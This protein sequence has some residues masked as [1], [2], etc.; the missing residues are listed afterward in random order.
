MD[1]EA[2]M[3][4][5]INLETVTAKIAEVAATL[6]ATGKA[7]KMNVG[8]EAPIVYDGTVNPPTV[9]NIDR[10][11][12]ATISMDNATFLELSEGKTTGPSAMMRGKLKIKGDMGAALGFQGIMD[13]VRKA[14]FD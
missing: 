12:Q 2:G 14:S 8:F 11:T 10:D 13:A 5:E 4:V 9:D 1:R 3:A 6:P 7:V